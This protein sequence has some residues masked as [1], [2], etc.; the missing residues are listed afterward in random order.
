M[1]FVSVRGCRYYYEEAGKGDRTV[2]FAHGFLLDSSLFR[3]QMEEFAKD[4]RVVAFDWRG[5]GRSEPTEGGYGIEDLYGDA[6]ELLKFFGCRERPCVWVGV[7]MGGFV[8]MRLA[9]RNPELLRGVVLADTGATAEKPLKKLVW[10]LMAVIFKALGPGAVAGGIKKALFSPHSLNKPFVG[11][12][13]RKWREWAK[14]KGRRE[15]LVRTAFAI[16][17]RPSFE[18]ELHRIRIPT[19]IVVGE[20]D[21][22]RPYGEALQLHRAIEGSRLV[23][24]PRAGHSSPLENPEEFNRHLREFL[25]EVFDE[26]R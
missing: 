17:N 3:Y 10:S 19:L 15:A 11:E 16:F 7:S 24:I 4:Y 8:G 2:V 21:R 6:V 5:Q 26:G 22:S 20:D 9:A 25:E 23:V 1:P 12:Y 18:G 13:E 14:D